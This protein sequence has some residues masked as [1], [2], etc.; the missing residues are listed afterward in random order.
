MPGPG[1]YGNKRK[2]RIRQGVRGPKWWKKNGPKPM[3]QPQRDGWE[4]AGHGTILNIGK[5]KK[6]Y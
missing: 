5:G 1:P 3:G 2:D 4:S 6:I